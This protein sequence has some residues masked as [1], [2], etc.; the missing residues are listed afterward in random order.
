MYKY[1]KLAQKQEADLLRKKIINIR[2]RIQNEQFYG[3]FID[4]AVFFNLLKGSFIFLVFFQ[5]ASFF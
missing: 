4:I 1:L 3:I 2:N 5:S